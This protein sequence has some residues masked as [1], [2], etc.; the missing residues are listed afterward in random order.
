MA[1]ANDFP[2]CSTVANTMHACGHDGHTVMLLGAARYLAETR[3]FRGTVRFIF[4]PAEENEAGGRL[5]VEEGLLEA[6]PVQAVYGMHNWPGL[7]VGRFAIRPGPM[8]AASD[9]FEIVLTGKG[10]HAAMLIWERT[11]WLPPPRS[12]QRCIT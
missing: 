10:A 11:R 8:M 5:M 4:Q 3:R 2:H 9:V 12:S 1:E 7:P 6:F